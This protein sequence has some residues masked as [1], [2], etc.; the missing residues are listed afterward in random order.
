MINAHSTI[1]EVS[2]EIFALKLFFPS[3]ITT[4][5]SGYYACIVFCVRQSIPVSTG[6]FMYLEF[7]IGMPGI[8]DT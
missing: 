2:T 1:L 3:K 6:N 7:F 8:L 5:P 4:L